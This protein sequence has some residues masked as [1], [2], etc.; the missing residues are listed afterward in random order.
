MVYL[1]PPAVVC[2][3]ADGVVE[4]EAGRFFVGAAARG[5]RGDFF[6]QFV[7]KYFSFRFSPFHAQRI[8]VIDA[9]LPN[10]LRSQNSNR[11]APGGC[12]NS[13]LAVRSM[14][15]R[16]ALSFAGTSDT[17][18][19][20]HMVDVGKDQHIH[21]QHHADRAY[22]NPV[23]RGRR[24]YFRPVAKT[25]NDTTKGNDGQLG[26]TFIYMGLMSISLYR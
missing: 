21:L 13:R 12:P 17:G 3:C 25:P 15:V 1:A 11:A 7:F 24:R 6:L 22:R 5:L 10:A 4:P 23:P 9:Q 26:R 16:P 14:L 18:A 2:G 8:R 20:Q 19:A